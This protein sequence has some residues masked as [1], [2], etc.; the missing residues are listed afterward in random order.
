[1]RVVH[2]T[3]DERCP[4]GEMGDGDRSED[5]TSAWMIR[6]D[7]CDDELVF[8]IRRVSLEGLEFWMTA[9][10]F[11]STLFWDGEKSW[12]SVM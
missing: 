12:A 3:Q 1:M 4:L 5:F 8:D 2:F 7:S 6:G 11:P 10:L 9:C